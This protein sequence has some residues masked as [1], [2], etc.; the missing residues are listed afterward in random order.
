MYV[1]IRVG[2]DASS[3]GA[4][5]E[6]E[7]RKLL[8][9]SQISMQTPLDNEHVNLDENSGDFQT[10]LNAKTVMYLHQPKKEIPESRYVF[11]SFFCP[12]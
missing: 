8:K 1:L 6:L 7:V 9:D 3:S 10:K 5:S 4:D 11:L 12:C 2:N